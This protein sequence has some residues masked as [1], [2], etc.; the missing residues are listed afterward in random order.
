MKLT[1]AQL[2]K[3]WALAREQRLEE[4][5]LRNVVEQVSGSP[6]ISSLT[7]EQA[8]KVIDRL[9]PLPAEPRVTNSYRQGMA[10]PKQLQFIRYLERELGWQDNPQ[11]LEGFMKKYCRG[12]VLL[13]WL[14]TQDANK[15]IES[16]KSVL[17]RE[18]SQ[19][20]DAL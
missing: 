11:R 6:S 18:R 13:E 20:G 3:I 5:E 7:K 10:T 8:N 4:C 16:L 14:T 17:S 1:P 12:I 9:T 15:L 2:K 19:R